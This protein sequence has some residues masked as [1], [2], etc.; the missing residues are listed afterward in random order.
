MFDKNVLAKGNTCTVQSRPAGPPG[1]G[2][3]LAYPP[4]VSIGI[5]T[6]FMPP[7]VELQMPRNVFNNTVA[8]CA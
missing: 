8:T 7:R 6:T 4:R 2:P 3:Q 5:M 1:W